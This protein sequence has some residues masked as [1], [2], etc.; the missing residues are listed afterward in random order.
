MAS[1]KFTVSLIN[2][3][4][5]HVAAKDHVDSII[6]WYT[7][8]GLDEDSMKDI[9]ITHVADSEFECRYTPM[10]GHSDLDVQMFVDNDEDGNYP[11]QI[12]KYSYSV[13][14]ELVTPSS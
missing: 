4:A 6:K 3:S 13:M 7:S 2:H 9:T 8:A 10:P 11:V 5:P 1:F 12:G 14:G